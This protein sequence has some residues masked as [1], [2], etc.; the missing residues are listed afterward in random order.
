VESINDRA[1]AVITKN[2]K[3]HDTVY[4]RELILEA[5]TN[6]Y[7]LVCERERERERGREGGRERRGERRHTRV[8]LP[9]RSCPAISQ[10]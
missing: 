5:S 4:S 10:S 1:E 3:M 2:K 9:K 6:S 7:T 8:M